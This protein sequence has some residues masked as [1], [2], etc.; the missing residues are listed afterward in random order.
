MLA[1]EVEAVRRRPRTAHRDRLSRRRARGRHRRAD[2]RHT[3]LRPCLVGDLHLPVR[4]RVGAGLH[5]Q[6]AELRR[7]DRERH[8]RAWHRDAERIGNEEGDRA[9]L[10]DP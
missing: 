3:Y 7:L 1:T 2:L 6:D 9:A 5:E 8:G 10:L 4:V